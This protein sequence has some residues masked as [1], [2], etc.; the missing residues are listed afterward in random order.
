MS[1]PVV[2]V[3]YSISER[4]RIS[5]IVRKLRAIVGVS[6]KEEFP[7]VDFLEFEFHKIR[8]D[9][10][11]IVESDDDFGDGVLAKATN[12]P[13]QIV[14]RESL[15]EAAVEGHPSARF[16]LAHELGHLCLSHRKSV[17]GGTRNFSYVEYDSEKQIFNAEWQAN[18]FAAEL[19]IPSDLAFVMSTDEISER[20]GVLPKFVQRRLALLNMRKM[21]SSREEE[22][23]LYEPHPMLLSGYESDLMPPVKGAESHRRYWKLNFKRGVSRLSS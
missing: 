17:Q 20:Y 23:P 12:S 1:T 2:F 11:L 15:Y 8:R 13:P 3:S 14:V 10:V 22:I 18:E 5:S 6:D 4:R 19:L 16:V 9:F 7:I 21:I